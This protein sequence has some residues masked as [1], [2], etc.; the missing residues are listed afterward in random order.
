MA[1]N[2]TAI[3]AILEIPPQVLRNIEKAERGI[4]ALHDASKKAA[5]QVY[6]D[7]SKRMP[8]GVDVFIKKL[9][10]AKAAMDGLGTVN[11]TLNTQ[12]AISNTE[13]L[14]EATR[15][16]STDVSRAVQDMAQSWNG[17]SKVSLKG[18]DITDYGNNLTE[19]LV[20]LK[21][22][23]QDLKNE[24]VGS[25][26][27]QGM[28]DE[29]RRVEEWIVLYKKAAEEKN[30][31]L[32]TI[33]KSQQD[34]T[35][36]TYLDEQKRLL[37]RILQLR[38]DIANVNISVQR[39]QITGKDV[40]NEVVQL[41][42]LRQE[43]VNTGAE[44]K[45]LRADKDSLSSDA[46][47]KAEAASQK[48][49]TESIK[50]T[51]RERNKLNEAITRG[52][53]LTA[54][55][56]QG[57]TRLGSGEEAA[58]QRQLNSDYKAM[59]K[60][61]KEQGELKAK[62]ASEGRRMTQDEINLVAA[63]GQRYKVYYD[64]VNRIAGAY[65][66]MSAAAAKNFQSDKSEQLAR[67]AILLADAQT[68]AATATEK[69]KK[70]LHD[71]SPV[72]Q[73]YNSINAQIE[74]E[75]RLLQQ[76]KEKADQAKQA[77]QSWVTVNPTFNYLD[78]VKRLDELKAKIEEVK[79][80]AASQGP[81]KASIT[82]AGLKPLQAEYD[83]INAKV[84]NLKSLLNQE[85]TATDNANDAVSRYTP[86]LAAMRD[87]SDR[88]SQKIERL[89]SA[90][91]KFN[92]EL[93]KGN[94]VKS[95]TTEY[96]TLIATIQRLG[97]Q[98]TAFRQAG[99]NVNSASYQAMSAQLQSAVARE[100]EI[101][102]MSINEVEQ[103]RRQRTQAAY[104]ADISAFIQAEA[105]KTAEAKKQ[106]EIRAKQQAENHNKYLNSAQGA[107]WYSRQINKGNVD[108]SY[109]NRERAIKQLENAI[110]SL[111]ANDKNYDKTLKQLT[112][113]MARLKNEQTAVNNAMKSS[114]QMVSPQDA[115]NAAQNARSLKDLQAA[116]K[117]LKVVMDA[118]NPKDAQWQN[119]N[120][121]Y[122]ETKKKIDDIR[123]AMGE[124]HNQ[125][126]QTGDMMGQ[127]RNQIAA[128]FSAQAIMGFIK[129]IVNVRAEFE[130]QNVALRAILQNKDEADRIFAQV[131]QMAMQ[132][133][134]T[135]MQLNTYTKQLAASRIESG[136]LLD[137]TKMLADVSAGLGVDMGRL[138]LAYGQVKSANYLRATEVRQFTEAGLNIAGELAQY[139]SELRG[140]MISVGD[141]M[142]MITK[143]MVRFEDV[144]EVFKRVTGAG[145][146]FYDMQKKQSESL[147]GQIQRISDAL[148]IMM[149][150]IGQDNQSAISAA[151]VMIRGL[152]QNW[153]VVVD[154]LYGAGAAMGAYALK[155]TIA[156]V[157]QAK[158]NT[159]SKG[160]VG[161]LFKV[162][163][164][165]EDMLDTLKENP[166]MLLIGA[167][168]AAIAA[169]SDLV[170]KTNDVK[171]SYNN[172][173]VGLSE[174]SK[175]LEGIAQRIEDAN[176]KIEST[177]EELSGLTKGTDE[178]TA[179]ADANREAV[180]EQY[181]ALQELRSKFPEVYAEIARTA[182][183]TG[184]LTAAIE[185]FNEANR[186]ASVIA[187][188]SEE[189]VSWFN[190][191]M[192]EDFKGV[193]DS[194]NKY[195]AQLAK[196][197]AH[198]NA[199]LAKIEA[200]YETQKAT[201]KVN[202]D[203]E[204]AHKRIIALNWEDLSQSERVA[205]I[206]KLQVD[207]YGVYYKNL[208][209]L[210]KDFNSEYSRAL[211]TG[212]FELQNNLNEAEKE[213]DAFMRRMLIAAGVTSAE[214]F[215][216]LP[217]ETQESAKKAGE[218][219]IKELGLSLDEVQ[220]DIIKRK[221]E[222]PLGIKFNF[223]GTV[224]EELSYM[225]KLINKYI[226]EHPDVGMPKIQSPTEDV[227]QYFKSVSQG[228][229]QNLEDEKRYTNAKVQ[230]DEKSTNSE[231][232]NIEKTRA[233]ERK[234]ML[235]YFGFVE[236]EKKKSS[237]GSGRDAI[238]DLWK[239]RLKA[240]QDFYKQYEELQ[241]NFSDNEALDKVKDSF[242]KLFKT[243]KLN[244][245]EVV[246]HG[247]G[248]K[249]LAANI[250][251]MLNQVR[252]IRPQLADEFE[253]AGA[254]VTVQIDV[255]IQKEALDR[256]K[257]DM[258]GVADNFELSETFRKLGV[259]TDLVFMLGGKPTTLAEYR[260][261]LEDTYKQTYLVEK[262]YG[263]EGVKAYEEQ[264]KKI[265]QL[266]QKDAVERAK[267]YSK[268]LANAYGN[269]AKV[270]LDYYAKLTQMEDDFIKYRKQLEKSIA[271][272]KTSNADKSKM[273]KILE[274]LPEQSKRA[275][276][277]MREEMEKELAKLSIDKVLKS[278]LFSEMFQDLGSLTNSVLDRMIQ[279]INDIR[280]SAKNL[281][282]SQVR[283]LAQYAEKLE[284]A[285]IDNSPF[286]EA[287]N[288]IKKAYELR[289]KGITA[290]G[291]SDAL[292][293]SEEELSRLETL[294][295]D[296]MFVLG[297]KEKSYEIDGNSLIVAGEQQ[298]I[299]EQ[300][301]TL[302]SQNTSELN[303]QLSVLD[304][305]S[306]ALVGSISKQR[307][308]VTTNAQ[309]VQVFKNAQT[310][311]QKFGAALQEVAKVGME[312]MNVI[313]SGIQLFGGEI[314]ESDQVWLDFVGNMLSSCVTL[315][316]AFVALGIEI[317]SVLGIIGIIATALSVVA[318]LFTAIFQAH[319]KRLEKQIGN[320]Q[321][322]VDKLSRAFDK[323]KTAIDNA[324]SFKFT[325]SNTELAIKNAQAQIKGYRE[326]IRLE[327]DKKKTDQDKIDEY[328]ET[329]EDLQ[330]EIDELS[331]KK[332]EVLGGFGTDENIKSAAEEFADAWEAGFN[333]TGDGLNALQDKFQEFAREMLKKQVWGRLAE[334]YIN[335]ILTAIDAAFDETGNMDVN[336]WNNAIQSMKDINLDA[337]NEQAK[338]LA[339]ALGFK[340]VSGELV[341]S[342]LQKGIQN[343]TEPQAAAIEAYLNSMRFA[344]FEQNTKLDTL[345]AA[346]Q[347]QYGNGAENPVVTELKGIRGVLDNIYS[348][349]TGLIETKV[350]RGDCLRIV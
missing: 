151:L 3:G 100:K 308:I 152:I 115:I 288:A 53:E 131:Q 240:V 15:R 122:G 189:D 26:R 43:L 280:N 279:K 306:G 272:P 324:F 346:I 40:S 215:K 19:V 219:V 89:V 143:R 59:L 71:I 198:G 148:S 348:K 81:T 146:L 316:I 270:M 124:L 137:T 46:Q 55:G 128:A 136:K 18:F 209:G 48:F 179:V 251:A 269:S 63:L 176:K 326:M 204:A 20:K 96:K 6:G 28:A 105:Q 82:L 102:M 291:A 241:K 286:Q 101:R 296:I 117:Q 227:D 211:K 255:E 107:M 94:N 17:L 307:D 118:T 225:Q 35:D 345:I 287:Y 238:L 186:M 193:S 165:I 67:N 129:K 247:M 304:D 22:M 260:K 232:A 243:L 108:N 202:R 168:V 5:D 239:N 320:T 57:K 328:L 39:G 314:S 292:A 8:L 194:Q 201:G 350:G 79:A 113:T 42:K 283:Q 92:S 214:M 222:I 162:K 90:N 335:P 311:T 281:T 85:K 125:S 226:D 97:E 252:E 45:K 153:K 166:Y 123:R 31:A 88:L 62:V 98:M 197:E 23:K 167:A 188:L 61:I 38:K 229:K 173:I 331:K 138:I 184:D 158:F 289:S 77:L 203:I 330:D 261:T 253:K 49:Y 244:M 144:E 106:A 299:T 36:K 75:N 163:E 192:K 27:S 126:R 236:E 217:S 24:P 9:M 1:E 309:N 74:R 319:D 297:V 205:E 140:K 47:T 195:N 37:D 220:R 262:K 237:R 334:Q 340:G 337:F 156:A 254:D 223:G 300:Q 191:D 248:K 230:L 12:P 302:L 147:Y 121:V 263:D 174:S 341:L 170:E 231:L 41:E 14:S 76:A 310:A 78:A 130:L 207:K 298:Q 221:I 181:R 109:E 171:E 177:K 218:K 321:K 182:A 175:K 83:A 64:D 34:K 52:N 200:I 228:R 349:F 114:K 343:I 139:F 284:N 87:E 257:T 249:G 271:D 73:A 342:D 95:L 180:T 51:L 305:Q 135:I 30:K 72:M 258:E 65:R 33:Q 216:E 29:I 13:R 190:E 275:A 50:E 265:E 235:E 256:I 80:K 339:E 322:R 264:L 336:K 127:L 196:S 273:F 150:E 68:K 7:F 199:L 266:E 66:N 212:Q 11:V 293:V 2:D 213:A 206:G 149:N 99:G 145:G 86:R 111:D 25:S 4:L 58:V 274:N 133:P 295:E 323:L 250:G 224:T 161:V 332:Y 338:Q 344:V 172:I 54:Q 183:K 164:S 285:K 16:T 154:L 185:E 21:Q 278:P 294:K 141:V 327:Q 70:A 234:A 313:T 56:Q 242:Q 112:T 32:G 69:S 10:E 267:N 116:Y 187:T 208:R 91:K 301:Q 282:L 318:G 233:S 259:T 329:I 245:D 93:S 347:L 157:A 277:N 132:S 333:E 155:T 325:T 290:K 276:V 134:F 210:F 104:Q 317:N 119:M 60:I 110:K 142:E 178:Y 160:L 84:Q 312:A 44:Y 103:F 246:D 315:G 268:Y 169:L 120:K 303:K 159:T